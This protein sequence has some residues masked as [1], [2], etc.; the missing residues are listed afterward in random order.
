M[1]PGR[2]KAFSNWLQCEP[3]HNAGLTTLIQRIADKD[4]RHVNDAQIQVRSIRSMLTGT[5]FIAARRWISFKARL[6]PRQPLN[7]WS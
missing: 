3:N 4:D 1:D 6:L 2:G 5:D 7:R